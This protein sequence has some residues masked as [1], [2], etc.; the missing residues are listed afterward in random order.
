MSI[1]KPGEKRHRKIYRTRRIIVATL[2]MLIAC[3]CAAFV[4]YYFHLVDFLTMFV[5]GI[6][7]IMTLCFFAAVIFMYVRYLQS[8]DSEYDE[9]FGIDSPEP[10]HSARAAQRAAK[11]AARAQKNTARRGEGKQSSKAD[12][13][14]EQAAEQSAEAV[15]DNDK[16][17]TQRTATAAQPVSVRMSEPTSELTES[18]D[19]R[20]PHGFNL[21]E[22]TPED[23]PLQ[24]EQ[25]TPET[26]VKPKKQ[27]IFE[28]IRA[29]KQENTLKKPR[30][31]KQPEP[32]EEA[33]GGLDEDLFENL[34]QN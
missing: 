20:E 32:A 5:N 1:P 22:L 14:S 18:L 9:A 15:A 13:Q 33:F 24:A 2:G 7:R 31:E 30:H 29:A 17:E 28:K 6:I 3:A 23:L 26:P 19:A 8:L 27:G 10:A 25:Q 34:K 12:E 21:P 4:L 11:A 16:A